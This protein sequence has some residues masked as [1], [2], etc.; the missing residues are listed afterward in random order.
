M[1]TPLTNTITD[2]ATRINGADTIDF[3]KSPALLDTTV[4]KL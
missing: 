4:Q 3:C 1:I 2:I